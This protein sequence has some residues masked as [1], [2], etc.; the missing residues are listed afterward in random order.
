MKKKI[1]LTMMMTMMT[2]PCSGEVYKLVHPDGKV[3]YL[4]TTSPI[5]LKR[6]QALL[7]QTTSAAERA[8]AAAE[9]AAAAAER[10]AIAAAKNTSRRRRGKSYVPA[11]TSATYTTKRR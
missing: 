5:D 3:E 10:A 2:A 7:S 9:R 6:L 11:F 4:S 8:A 1:F